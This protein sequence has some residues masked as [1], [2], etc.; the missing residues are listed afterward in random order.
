MNK[1]MMRSVSATAAADEKTMEKINRLAAK[2]LTAD[3]VYCFSVRLCDNEIDRDGERF[4]VESLQCMAPLFVGKTGVFDHQWSAKEQ[5]ARL[6]DT[7]VVPGDGLTQTGERYCYLKGYAYMVRTPGREALIADI[8]GG[9]LRE[10]SVGL[11]CAKALC[12][13]CGQKAG[14]CGH[15]KG[16][17]IDNQVCHT[18]L[19]E[20]VDAYEWSFVAVPAQPAAGVIKAMA[21]TKTEK[22]DGQAMQ[23]LEKEAAFGRKYKTVMAE[24]TV[25]LLALQGW[26]GDLAG[27]ICVRM[28]GEE[29]MDLHAFLQDK[30]KKSWHSQLFDKDAYTVGKAN[31]GEEFVV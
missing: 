8:E 31:K 10:V 19:C 26:P 24:E 3:E 18:L 5:L 4:T 15:A 17:W 28:E 14:T 2:Q 9:I 12:S 27:R 21:K 20:P 13:V 7:E 30:T 6:Y 23:P 29:L 1:Q 11:R 25:R 16:T 22:G